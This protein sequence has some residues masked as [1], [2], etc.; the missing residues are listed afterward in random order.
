MEGLEHKVSAQLGR[1][2]HVI[3]RAIE[4][5]MSSGMDQSITP[6]Q[7]RTILYIAHGEKKGIICQRDIEEA[8]D[9]QP[10]S[11]SLLLRNME[12]NGFI[13]RQAVE[14][15]GRLKSVHLT[16]VAQELSHRLQVEFDEIERITL[17]GISQEE[18]ET[19][20]AILKKM[21]MNLE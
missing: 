16:P 2:H 5:K 3:M 17:R 14:G 7:V 6:P 11:V 18:Q 1:I 4:A 10:S 9:L 20:F 8:F 15:D 13:Y 12:K 21:R 19:F